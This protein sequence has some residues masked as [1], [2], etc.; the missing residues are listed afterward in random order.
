MTYAN[1]T[2]H[3]FLSSVTDLNPPSIN[4][5]SCSSSQLNRIL[6]YPHIPSVHFAFRRSCEFQILQASILNYASQELKPHPSLPLTLPPLSHY[7][8]LL[9]SFPLPLKCPVFL[10][11]S[12]M[13]T[14]FVHVEPFSRLSPV[15][16]SNVW[17]LLYRRD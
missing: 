8:S 3:S 12:S 17:K 16:S 10:K 6:I 15:S 1:M 4:P 7:L 9:F 14:F 5:S 2:L 13:F 11:A